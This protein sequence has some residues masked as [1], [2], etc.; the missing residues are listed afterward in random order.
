MLIS[1]GL[2]KFYTL[3]IFPFC[4]RRDYNSFVVKWILNGQGNTMIRYIIE[5][6]TNEM[7]TSP[8]RTLDLDRGVIAQGGVHPLSTRTEWGQPKSSRCSCQVRDQWL[9]LRPL[10]E[11]SRGTYESYRHRLAESRTYVVMCPSCVLARR[12]KGFPQGGPQFEVST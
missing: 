4:T 11:S 9:T 1:I 7:T 3:I 10:T 2:E 5:Q 6:G 12:N 8:G